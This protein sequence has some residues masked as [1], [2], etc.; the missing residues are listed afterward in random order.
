MEAVSTIDEVIAA[1]DAIVQREWAAGSAA[2]YFPALY[3]R[4]TVAVK[5][6]IARGDF[7]DNARMERLDVLFAQ[8][9]LEADAAWSAGGAVPGSWKAAFAQSGRDLT[10]LQHLLL[11]MNAH[12]G[13]DLGLSTE[14]CASGELLDLKADFLRINDILA[15]ELE[16]TQRRLT[17]IVGPLGLVDRLLGEIDEQLSIFSLRYARA[18]AWTQALELALAKGEERERLTAARDA[19][20]ADFAHC[21]VRPPSLRARWLLRL[22]RWLERGDVRWRLDCLR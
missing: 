3:G 14:A 20:V 15:A 1:L 19:A 16:G 5:E 10:V 22:V 17:R 6:A 9:Y 12:I 18:G 21:L 7:E 8:R 2:G 4:V 11:G 13:F